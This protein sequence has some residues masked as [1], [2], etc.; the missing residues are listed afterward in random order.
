[1]EAAGSAYEWRSQL[2]KYAQQ[3]WKTLNGKQRAAIDL[4]AEDVA[5]SR[6]WD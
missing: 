2:G 5:S 3:I 4:D 1:L 6:D